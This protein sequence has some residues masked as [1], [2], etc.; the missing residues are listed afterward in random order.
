MQRP[1]CSAI[2]DGCNHREKGFNSNGGC[3]SE[4]TKHCSCVRKQK[5][6]KF[7]AREGKAGL[8]WRNSGEKE[9]LEYPWHP[10]T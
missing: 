6:C 3:Q 4:H 10:S 8:K 7:I 1:A 9:G 5:V 2:T